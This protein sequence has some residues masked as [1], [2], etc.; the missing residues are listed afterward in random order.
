MW[1][2][3]YAT[4]VAEREKGVDNA[5]LAVKLG[6]TTRR[7]YGL[8]REWNRANPDNPLPR[9]SYTNDA[10]YTQAA[11]MYARGADRKE[12]AKHFNC[13][14][15]RVSSML[16]RARDSGLLPRIPTRMQ[17]GGDSAYLALYVKG[18]APPIGAIRTVLRALSTAEIH[19]LLACS[20]T[21][22]KTLAHTITRI[23]KEHLRDNSKRR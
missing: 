1:P 5:A 13:P 9:R 11:E 15:N 12:I 17:R 22:D 23:V 7:L 8:V 3:P 2:E 16:S 19:R 21:G 20:E 10:L 4:I 18:A 6:V 14:P